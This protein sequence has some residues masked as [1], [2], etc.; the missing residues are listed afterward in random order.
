MAGPR[1][2]QIVAAVTFV[3]AV[4]LTGLVLVGLTGLAVLD[5]LEEF[6]E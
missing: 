4:P 6:F 3:M 1:M 2:N 5:A